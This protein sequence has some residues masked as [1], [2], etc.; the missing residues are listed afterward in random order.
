M[1]IIV[2]IP[3]SRARISREPQA[4]DGATILFFTGVRYCRDMDPEPE[5]DSALMAL[6]EPSPAA[7]QDS[8]MVAFI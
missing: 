6:E 3:A 2:K 7:A 5:E 1:A 4:E 8:G